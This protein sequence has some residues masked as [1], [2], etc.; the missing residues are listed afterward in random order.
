MESNVSRM[1]SPVDEP[2]LVAQA[3]PSEARNHL[4]GIGFLFNR[5]NCWE[6]LLGRLLALR[7][8]HA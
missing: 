8:L 1:V 6:V 3:R 5:G 4:E 7:E 2:R